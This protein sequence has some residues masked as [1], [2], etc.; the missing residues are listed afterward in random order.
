MSESQ[1]ID[2]GERFDQAAGFAVDDVMQRRLRY[3]LLRLT[4]I[5][6]DRDELPEIVEL[7][8]AAFDDAD[9]AERAAAIRDR[10]GATPIASAIAGVVERSRSGS[11]PFAPRA[12]VLLGAVIGAYAGLGDAGA[13]D[14][15]RATT[16]AVLGAVGGGTAASMAPFIRQQIESV[17]V[18]EYLRT[19]EQS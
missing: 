19:D 15:A 4:A 8:R 16:A 13:A 2:A 12:D 11:G 9:V 6:L 3:H 5:G 1:T 7:A 10:P 14:P 17:G 18:A